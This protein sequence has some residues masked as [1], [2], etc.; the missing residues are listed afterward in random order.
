M[1]EPSTSIARSGTRRR[2]SVSGRIALL[3]AGVACS[4]VVAGF[5]QAG[6]GCATQ[7]GPAVVIQEP[8]PIIRLSPDHKVLPPAVGLYHGVFQPPA[9]E[10]LTKLDAYAAKYGKSPAIVMWYQ[11]WIDQPYGQFKTD[12]V[13]ALL[14]RGIVPLI[15]WEPWNPGGDPHYLTNPAKQPAYK[16]SKIVRGDYDAYIRSWAKAVDGPIMLRPMHEMNGYWYPW[17]G[18]VNGNKPA[19]FRAAW[20]HVHAIFAEEGV[21]NVT[22]VWSINWCSSP[23][24][25]KNHYS[26]YYPGDGYVDWTSISGFNWGSYPKD[27]KNHSFSYIYTKPFAYLSKLGKPVVISEIACNTGVNKPAWIRD[28]YKRA[29]SRND[30]VKGIVYYDYRE[31]GA[32]GTQNWHLSSTTASEKAY[33]SAIA[34]ALFVG[35]APYSL[36][37]TESVTP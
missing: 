30:L 29:L 32:G 6:L 8:Q 1:R 23:N 31:V 10:K 19:D 7:R 25:T 17:S 27:P 22:W 3:L 13:K 5:A 35:A 28:A 18:L 9:P 26:A 16:L 4:A 14:A 36:L 34:S 12:A 20:R 2:G 15:T 24:S 37:G 21:T 11:P 33:K